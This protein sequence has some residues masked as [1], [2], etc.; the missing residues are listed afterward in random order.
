VTPIDESLFAFTSDGSSSWMMIATAAE[1]AQFLEEVK[2]GKWD[3]ILRQ[4]RA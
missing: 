3:H 4:A 1:T 2:A